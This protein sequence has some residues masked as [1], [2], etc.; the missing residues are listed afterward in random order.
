MNWQ[1]Q[2]C[3]NGYTIK[4]NLYVQCNTHQN[5]HDILHKEGKINPKVHME[6]QKSLNSQSNLE[7]KEQFYSFLET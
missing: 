4:S 5:S 3:E 1:D 7:H 6:T 2:Y